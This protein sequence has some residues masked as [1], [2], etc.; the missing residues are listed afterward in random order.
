MSNAFFPTLPGR[1]FP[2]KKSPVWQTIDPFTTAS[3][4][5]FRVGFETFPRWKFTLQY[6]F[7]RDTATYSELSTLVGFF[8]ARLGQLDTFLYT[9]PDES[10]VSSYQFGT[11]DGVTTQFA[12]ARPFGGFGEP[13][14]YAV[15]SSVLN[16]GSAVAYTLLQNRIVQY[17]V[18]P[19]SGA[20]LVWSGTYAYRCRF[21]DPSMSD[22]QKFMDKLWSGS[23]SFITVKP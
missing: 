22:L 6:E 3:G 1:A 14:G 5:E 21:L 11:G 10:S 23:I 12:L 20:P 4:R 15:P 9:D 7:L 17:S 16:N 8:L 18:A 2:A 19:S 13:V